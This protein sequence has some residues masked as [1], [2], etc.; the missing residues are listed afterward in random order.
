MEKLLRAARGIAL[1]VAILPAGGCGRASG[2]QAP[3]APEVGVVVVQPQRAMISTQLPGRTVAY[4]IAQVRPR[5]SGIIKAR[6]Y[7]EGAEVKAGQALYQ[8]DPAPYQ[9]AYDSAQAAVSKAAANSLAVKLKFAR[10]QKL[11][12]TGDVSQQDRD[13]VTANLSQAEADEKTARAALETARINLDYT[14]IVAPIAG[15]TATSAYTEGALVTAEQDNPLTTVQQYAPMYVDL[16]Q[17]AAAL[18]KLRSQFASG[19]LKKAD[20]HSASVRLQ[21]DDGSY[22]AHEGSLEVTGVTVSES[23][24]TVTL[25]AVFPNPDGLLL[26]GMY[27]RAELGLAVDE[28]ALLVPQQAVTRDARG[29][30]VTLVVGAGDKVEPRDLTVEA[31]GDRWRVLSG[32]HAGERVV[33]QGQLKAK[34]GKVVRPVVV[35]P[36]AVASAPAG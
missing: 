19:A 14:R 21:L 20:S 26:P 22:Y 28:Q 6:L 12:A 36:G 10:V 13:D 18:L 15:R 27:V 31:A 35:E 23:T 32:L 3:P 9:A 33:V 29:V 2:P 7:T 17:P 11:A 16:T 25:R 4:R 8:L 1:A 5:V 30:A 34:P 24:G